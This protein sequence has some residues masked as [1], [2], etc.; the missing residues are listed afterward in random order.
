MGR[1]ST[2]A[3]PAVREGLQPPAFQDHDLERIVLG[4]LVASPE[5]FNELELSPSLFSRTGHRLIFKAIAHLEKNGGVDLVLLK[6]HLEGNGELEAAGGPAYV[7]RLVDGMPPT[8]PQRFKETVGRLWKLAE[9]RE[10]GALLQAGL[11]GLREGTP[12]AEII[13]DI[14]R[15]SEE[16]ITPQKMTGRFSIGSVTAAEL[17]NREVE[18]PKALIGDF[19][20]EGALAI[21][22]GAPGTFKTW[23]S[24][25]MAVCLT[26]A[27]RSFFGHDSRQCPTGFMSFELPLFYVQERL[28]VL[29]GE[30]PWPADLHVS[31]KPDLQGLLSIVDP[32]CYRELRVWIEKNCLKVV[33]LDALSRI[34]DGDE[35][36][37][38]LGAVLRQCDRL[39][40]E[41]GCC[42]FLVHHERKAMAGK[43]ADDDMAALRGTSRLASDPTV[44]MRIREHRG[45]YGVRFVKC[46]LSA[47]PEPFYFR[48]S[49]NRGIERVDEPESASDAKAANLER[50][51]ELLRESGRVTAEAVAEDLGVTKRTALRYL[52]SIEAVSEGY[53]AS[54]VWSLE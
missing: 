8:R 32:S 11:E 42:V 15:D 30:T 21:L 39:R 53:G 50:V 17:Q 54:T 43:G 38:A 27:E 6:R 26:T 28:T 29:L 20:T 9:A 40:E 18:R 49:E 16:I 34:H 31:A 35:T 47:T 14:I 41:T 2:A 25:L 51:R 4:M 44:L 3:R 36:F 45:V 19:L 24:L 7:G 22:Y 46:S 48:Q 37:E 10:T 12:A 23:L 52:K 5:L 33:F 1:K 13:N